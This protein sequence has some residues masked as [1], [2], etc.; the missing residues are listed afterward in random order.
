MAA[1]GVERMY[2]EEKRKELEYAEMT[3]NVIKKLVD[4]ELSYLKKQR[5]DIVKDR[6]YFIDYFYEL[7][8]DEKMDLLK[9]EAQDTRM[10]ESTLNVLAKLGRQLKEPYFARFDFQ[11]VSHPVDKFYIGIHTVKDPETDNIII[12]DWRAPIASLYYEH[13][14]GNASYKAPMGE[15]HGLLHLKRRYVFKNGKLEKFTDIHMPSDDEFLYEVL[16]RNSDEKMKV[17]VQT[18]QKEQNRIIRDYIE[19]VSVIQGCPGSGKSSIALHKAAYVLY[20]FRDRLRN[21]QLAIISP[22]KVFAEYISSVLPDLGEENINQISPEE[23]VG[24]FLFYSAGTHYLGRLESQEYILSAN[25]TEMTRL[26]KISAFKCTR[27]FSEIV[28]KYVKHV[29]KSLFVPEDL[30]LDDELTEYIDKETLEELFYDEFRSEAVY[31][32]TALVAERVAE[33]RKIKSFEIKEHIKEGLDSMITCHSVETLYYR[34]YQD[35][36]FFDEVGVNL[37]KYAPKTLLWE[38]ICAIGLMSALMYKFEFEPTL[39]YLLADEAQ[40]F[41]PVFL[42]LI[43]RRFPHCNMLF[44]GDRK[45]LVF[46]NT[47][48]F[49]DDIRDIIQRRPFRKYELTTNYRST[50]EIIEFASH[51]IN[52][53]EE[54]SIRSGNVPEVVRTGKDKMNEEVAKFVVDMYE[55]GYMN[56]AVLCKSMK[57]AKEVNL[58]LDA[59]YAVKI[60]PVYLAK[61]LEF[62]CV[63]IWNASKD[64]YYDKSDR[65]MLYTAC[66][67]AMHELRV[68]Y[69]GEITP[70]LK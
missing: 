1:T 68:F 3:I 50:N 15:I 8:D 52:K 5:K 42:E 41:A 7:K 65:Q 63:A 37:E 36:K 24:D 70:F 4:E 43:K 58:K 21:Q 31:E 53:K 10:Y 60:L 13:E 6:T 54:H 46:E 59:K 14:P 69:Q 2:T 56:I 44:V 35:R 62:D 61:G 38:D 17:I 29:E 57:S 39:F 12:Y 9:A 51:I 28:K 23:I 40:D 67:R 32:R 34:M 33:M 48:N 47:G 22:N 16:S 30:Y 45:Q 27:D 26:R 20:H 49:V 66:T 55:K 19:G 11:E 64:E 25:K 18:L